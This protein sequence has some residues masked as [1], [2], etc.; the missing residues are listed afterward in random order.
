MFCQVKENVGT[1]TI[2]QDAW[3]A[4]WDYFCLKFDIGGQNIMIYSHLMTLIIFGSIYCSFYQLFGFF[5]SWDFALSLF[6]KVFFE[7]AKDFWVLLSAL[8]F[9]SFCELSALCFLSFYELSALCF[10]SFYKP[11]ALC[12]SSFYEPSAFCFS[13]FYELSE[14]ITLTRLYIGITWFLN[15]TCWLFYYCSLISEVYIRVH[16]WL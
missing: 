4:W 1:N 9:T 2:S 15:S 6:F 10:L 12:F 14:Q 13:S 16:I 5:I 8:C 11:S 7:Q 3:T